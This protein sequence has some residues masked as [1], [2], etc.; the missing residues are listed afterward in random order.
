MSQ[1]Y[2]QLKLDAESQKYLVINTHKGLFCY[3]RLPFGISTAPGIFQKAMETLLQG[4]PHVTYVNIDDILITGKN[5]VDHLQTL[6][7]VLEHLAK[8]GLRAKKNKCKFMVPSV[9]YLGYVIDSPGLHLHLDK[10][11]A[12]QQA[13][14]LS[15]VIQ[16]K[17]YLGLLSY[18][19]KFIQNL[20]TLLAPLYKLLGKHFSWRWLSEQ[21]QAF[22]ASKELLMSSKLLV[23]F[24]PQLPLLLVCDASAYGIGAMLAHNMPDGSEQLQPI[25]YVSHTLNSAEHNYSQLEKGGLSCVY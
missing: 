24:N 1:A 15:N 5:D 7:T 16:L 17:S 8:A 21:E 4:I 20:P 14:T 13:P 12:I 10:V 2:Q 18:Y 23:H 19:R 11:S 9:D 3:T 25:G 6:E 22:Q